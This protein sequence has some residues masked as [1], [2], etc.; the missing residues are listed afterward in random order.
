M[1]TIT[2]MKAIPYLLSNGRNI[3]GLLLGLFFLWMGLSTRRQRRQMR[4]WT[5]VT[6]RI[7]ERTT[8]EVMGEK[9][10]RFKP[11]AT[12]SY[13]VNGVSYT[14]NE[15]GFVTTRYLSPS[16]AQREADELPDDVTVHYNPDKPTEAILD[17]SVPGL[18][19]PAFIVGGLLIITVVMFGL[20]GGCV[21]Q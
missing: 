9:G 3:F 7:V 10:P 12:Y 19:A 16:T 14:G 18:I 2:I 11:R 17:P 6:G 15:I 8:A 4:C 5:V 13:S 21:G 1:S 20:L